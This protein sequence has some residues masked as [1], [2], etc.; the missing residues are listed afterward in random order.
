MTN[1]KIKS[2]KTI[3][4]TS[5]KE[6]ISTEMDSGPVDEA[7]KALDSANDIQRAV[8]LNSSVKQKAPK[9]NSVRF[10]VEPRDVP[11][12]KVARR[13][14]LTPSEFDALL[15]ALRARRFPNPDPTTGY[16]DLKKVDAWM[17]ARDL[18]ANSGAR[19]ARDGFRDRIAKVTHGRG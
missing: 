14:H 7:P 17:D 19:D 15:P 13:L 5:T 18:G 9:A 1:R 8:G 3:S 10:A 6:L 12:E 16:Y 11:P 2:A 4:Q